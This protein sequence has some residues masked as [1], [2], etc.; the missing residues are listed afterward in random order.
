MDI[1]GDEGFRTLPPGEEGFLQSHAGGEAVFLKVWEGAKAG[2]GDSRRRRYCVQKQVDSWARRMPVLVNAYLQMKLN[3]PRRTDKD[4]PGVWFIETLGF[5]ES[6][7]TPFRY[8]DESKNANQTLVLHG[9]IGG[10]PEQPSIAFSVETFEIYRQVH[11]VCPR[12]SIDGLAKLAILRGVDQRVQQALGRSEQWRAKNICPP[13]FYKLKNEP[14]LSPSWMGCMDGNNSLKLIDSTFR[15][16]LP[17]FDNRKADSFCWLTTAEVDVFKDEVKNAEKVPMA[18]AAALT[19]VTESLASADSPA[20]PPNADAASMDATASQA[21]PPSASPSADLNGEESDELERCINTC[22]DRWRNAGPEARKK[23]FALFAI[24]GIFLAVCRHGHVLAICDMIRSGELV[25]YPLA[26]VN[27]L[28]D[29]YPED[30]EIGYDIWCAFVKTLLRSSLGRRV[31]GLRL[32]GVV[33]SFHG[34]AHNRSCQLGWHP[35]YVDGSGLEDFEECEHTFD[36]SN[37]LA[38]HAASGNFIFS[39]Y[40]QA[41]EK[42][43]MTEVS[44]RTLEQTLCTTAADYEKYIV[45]ERTYL[46]ALK[47]EAPEVVWTVEYMELLQKRNAAE[48]LSITAAQDF[49]NLDHHIIYSGWTAPKIKDVKTKYCTTYSRARMLEEE[50]TRFEEEHSIDVR[51]LPTSKESQGG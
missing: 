39:N 32:T 48:Q 37:N 17:R 7:S 47:H 40:R 43:A 34:H 23:M 16:G 10:S 2:R 4:A 8:T 45:Q 13:C 36:L 33:P 11:R 15:A 46:E 18:M 20:V 9:Y 28:L 21:P 12:F 31:V 29:V 25:K 5:S 3:G 49:R 26:I 19:A 44:L 30:A 6:Q 38:S 51:W 35:L 24:S 41:T 42:I 50:L 22:V 1:D 14:H 27:R